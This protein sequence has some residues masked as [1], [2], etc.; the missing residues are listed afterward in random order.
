M[1]RHTGQGKMMMMMMH[2]PRTMASVSN[3]NINSMGGLRTVRSERRNQD[4][5]KSPSDD[6][7]NDDIWGH[8]RQLD[9]VRIDNLRRLE[10][11]PLPPPP[12]LQKKNKE[13]GEKKDREE[14]KLID[15]FFLGS[16]LKAPKSTN[17]NSKLV[18]INSAR[19]S[20]PFTPEKKR[21][22][23]MIGAMKRRNARRRGGVILGTV[24]CSPL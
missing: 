18:C 22:M 4:E 12:L 5:G 19:K 6:D 10:M 11:C 9:E 15:L 1:N 2:F 16:P 17:T 14:N 20:T 23:I 8:I 24:L 3:I 13:G 21:A 7:N